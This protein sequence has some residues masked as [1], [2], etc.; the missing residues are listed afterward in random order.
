[1]IDMQFPKTT[2][3]MEKV[4]YFSKY[5]LDFYQIKDESP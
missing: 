1:M 2:F 4:G 3:V 5:S